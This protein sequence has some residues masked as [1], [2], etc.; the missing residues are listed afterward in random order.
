MMQKLLI[1]QSLW[2]MERRNTDG[3]EL[4]L[5][6]N[7]AAISEAGFDG[8][9]AHY[10]SHGDVIRLNQA[11]QGTG[12]KIE[13]VCFPRCVE[14]LRLP[15]EL[16][17]AFPVSHINLQPDIRPRRID[18]CLPLLDGWMRLAEDAGIPVFIE[19]HRDR[20]TTDLFFTLDLLERRP[21]LPLLADLSHFLVGREFAFPVDEENHAFIRRILQNAHAFHGRVA[22][23]EQVQIEIS[24]P[25]HRPWLDLFLQWWDYG[26]RHWRSRAAEDAELVFTCELGPKPYAITGRDGNDST[27]RWAEALALRQMVRELWPAIT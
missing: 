6:D 25:H 3:V 2:A 11:I 4:R 23:C 10:T 12:L 27:D 7:I 22:S 15:L 19:T 26:F 5:D 9:S 17:A 14:D 1:F 21:D 18:D 24:F 8:I 16:A 20:M 13:A